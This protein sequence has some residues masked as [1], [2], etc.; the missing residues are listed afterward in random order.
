MTYDNN[1]IDRLSVSMFEIVCRNLRNLYILIHPKDSSHELFGSSLTFTSQ[2]IVKSGR[3]PPESSHPPVA[4]MH[5]ST[6]LSLS[7]P[8]LDDNGVG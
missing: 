8:Q 4:G 2:T 7:R 5:S 1:F 6:H 3:R